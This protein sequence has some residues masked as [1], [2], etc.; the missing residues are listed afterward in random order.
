MLLF[1]CS[2]GS[3]I[4]ATTRDEAV[5]GGHRSP[6]ALPGGDVPGHDERYE[7]VTEGDGG[8]E[9]GVNR[10]DRVAVSSDFRQGREN[11]DGRRSDH[12]RNERNPADFA[13]AF[14]G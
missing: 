13:G 11:H 7:G 4:L 8:H 1:A 3:W 5:V 10:H 12:E 9:D 2:R 6:V 14:S